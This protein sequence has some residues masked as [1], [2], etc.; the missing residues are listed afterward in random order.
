M[1]GLEEKTAGELKA[2][3]DEYPWFA[4]ARAA[5]IEK[6]AGRAAGPGELLENMK[7]HALFLPSLSDFL[8]IHADRCNESPS[9]AAGSFS[10]GEMELNP[11][12]C[13]E[14]LARIY[15]KQQLFDKA[16]AIYEKLILLYP[17][18]SVYFASLID[19]LKDKK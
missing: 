6:V 18:K 8:K 16:I 12:F 11:A 5:Y 2:I 1:V 9:P 17:E 3:V 15:E 14:T 10:T 19:E 4:A 7:R 13:T